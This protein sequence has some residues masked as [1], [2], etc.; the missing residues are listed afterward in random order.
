MLFSLSN[1]LKRLQDSFSDILFNKAYRLQVRGFWIVKGSRLGL[2]PLF[3]FQA[4]TA[5][6]IAERNAQFLNEHTIERGLA[7]DVIL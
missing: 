7:V 2:K 4:H 1:V 5:V 3:L 6:R